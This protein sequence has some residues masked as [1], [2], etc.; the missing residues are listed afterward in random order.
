MG[1]LDRFKKGGEQEEITFPAA[2][3]SPVKGTFVAMEQ[4]PDEVFSTGVLGVCCGIDP[5][6]GTVCAPIGGKISQLAETRHA[7]GIEA[8]GIEVLIHV[9][10]DT[11]E[12]NGDGFRAGVKVGQSVKKGD[13]LLTVDLDKVQAAG[14]PSTII[15]AVTN[16]DDFSGVEPVASGA[17]QPG[18]EVLRIS[19]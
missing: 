10:V 14:H 15:L 19:K 18:G 17:V 11:V 5:E 13:L 1:F 2:I 6:N 8:G 12:M 4:I 9:G 16:S 7:V 3:G